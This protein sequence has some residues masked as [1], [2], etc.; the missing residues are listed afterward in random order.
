MIGVRWRRPIASR[1]PHSCPVARRGTAAPTTRAADEGPRS[2]SHARARVARVDPKRVRVA[3]GVARAS[4]RVTRARSSVLQDFCEAIDPAREHTRRIEHIDARVSRMGNGVRKLGAVPD[5]DVLEAAPDLDAGEV[6]QLHNIPVSS[7]G[8]WRSGLA[9]RGVCKP[10]A[11]KTC[12]MGGSREPGPPPIARRG[13]RPRPL[14]GGDHVREAVPHELELAKPLGRH[15]V[16]PGLH[17]G[18]GP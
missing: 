10:F 1:V 3:E 4:S 16:V 14:L 17:R 12:R 6:V 7:H 5:S 15:L 8:R 9:P 2:T 11:A 13:A 18:H